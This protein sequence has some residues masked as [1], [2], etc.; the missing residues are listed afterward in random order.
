MAR[1]DDGEPAHRRRPGGDADLHQVLGDLGAQRLED[2][3]VVQRH[4][5]AG[6]GQ[7]HLDVGA[8]GAVGVQ[9]QHAVGEDEGLV[10]VVG[11]H[12]D[13]A[14]LGLPD[15][16]DLVGEVGAGERVERG[17]RLVHQ[18][19]LGLHGERAGD[20][21]ALAHAA[22]E[23]GRLAVAGV[24]EADHGDVAVDDARRARPAD[25]RLVHGVD[26]EARCCRRPRARAS[27]RRTGRPARARGRAR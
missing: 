27:A 22:G 15:A 24:G 17:E 21:D 19:H 5:V 23:L 11:D 6:A 3:V 25:L 10:D 1:G 2:R 4:A 13:G 14:A 26:G 16:L 20:G 7:R 9:D 18:E 8:E 12:E